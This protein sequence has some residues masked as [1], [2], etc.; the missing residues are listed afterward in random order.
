MPT[1]ITEER[2][3]GTVPIHCPVCR[4]NNVVGQII[5]SHEKLVQFGVIPVAANTTWWVLCPQCHTRLF[6]KLPASQ[7]TG[8]T[9][10]QLAGIVYKRVSLVAKFL[11][12]VSVALAWLPI[13]GIVMGLIALF[14]NRKS[15]GW[16][17][18]V[19]KVGFFGS[20]FF[21]ALFTAL[22]IVTAV[23]RR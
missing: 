20:L 18:T 14:A 16:P 21:H 4:G 6:S 9:A 23:F 5:E 2:P 22:E 17:K 19:S 12:I 3:A 15:P 8:K 7:L 13:L 11:A 1:V 10:D